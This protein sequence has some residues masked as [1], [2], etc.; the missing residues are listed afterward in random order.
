MS[1]RLLILNPFLATP[2]KD[3]PIIAIS[4]ILLSH[5]RKINR[6]DLWT[7]VAIRLSFQMRTHPKG[8]AAD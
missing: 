6:Q 3:S 5:L 2:Q 1:G 8:L 7:R 4:L